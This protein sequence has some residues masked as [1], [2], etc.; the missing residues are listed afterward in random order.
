MK[1]WIQVYSS[2]KTI[3]VEYV[4][5]L[6]ADAGIDSVP[7]SQKD[8]SYIFGEIV[9]FVNEENAIEAKL[10]ITSNNL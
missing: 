10:I 7:V 8:S 6:L 4:R 3:E 2:N 1:D 5:T 9:L